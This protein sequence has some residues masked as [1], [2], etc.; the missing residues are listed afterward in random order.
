MEFLTIITF[1]NYILRLTSSDTWIQSQSIG[2]RRSQIILTRLTLALLNA[3]IFLEW[4]W[5]R[6][7]KIALVIFLAP[8]SVESKGLRK[9]ISSYLIYESKNSPALWPIFPSSVS[10]YSN[11]YVGAFFSMIHFSRQ[12]KRRTV[13]NSFLTFF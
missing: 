7:L 2:T 6:I 13:Q 1:G 4:F 8:K 3:V 5:R 11:Q 9:L 10:S 12:T